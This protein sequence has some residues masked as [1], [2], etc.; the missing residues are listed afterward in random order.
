MK[1]ADVAATTATFQRPTSR[2]V[3]DLLGAPIGAVV[4][5]AVAWLLGSGTIRPDET[6]LLA[7]LGARFLAPVVFGG[8][9]LL[10]AS[11]VPAVLRRGF[12]R[13]VLRIGPDG[14]W[15]PEMGLL[16]WDEIAD[17]RLEAVRGFAGGDH[18]ESGSSLTVGSVTISDR[19]EREIPMTTYGR[20]GIVPRDPARAAAVRRSLAW[21]MTGG[22]LSAA[23][24]LRPS[25]NVQD[26]A[27]LAPFGVYAYDIGGALGPAVAA[28]Q[29][30][31]EVSGLPR[32]I[33]QPPE[34]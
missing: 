7:T 8:F 25:A 1:S 4:F 14:M 30:Y 27:D 17:V 21:R 26:L 29:R 15:T 22:L 5:L 32:R 31:R 34:S 3:V 20:L 9:G 23:R 12:T 2:V 24:S 18:D 11:G 28:V 10:M 19:H 6:D 16:S 33:E 13:T